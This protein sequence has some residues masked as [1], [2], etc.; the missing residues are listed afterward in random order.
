MR[1]GDAISTRGAGQALRSRVAGVTLRSLNPGFTR[2]ALVALGALWP[3]R[4]G[5]SGLALDALR[6]LWASLA[7]VPLRTLRAD[8]SLYA[9]RTLLAGIPFGT[10]R[11]DVSGIA[12]VALD[13][14]CHVGGRG[15]VLVRDGDGRTVRGLR[16]RSR[17][18]E[19]IFAVEVSVLG[20]GQKRRARRIGI[21][22]CRVRQLGSGV[23]RIRS[24]GRDLGRVLVGVDGIHEQREPVLVLIAAYDH[25][26]HAYREHTGRDVGVVPARDH[27]LRLHNSLGL[28]HGGRIVD[29]ERPGRRVDGIERLR[30]A[31]PGHLVLP[32]EVDCRAGQ[33]GRSAALP[34]GKRDPAPSGV[35]G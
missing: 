28:L 25:G 1:A 6:S 19:P 8:L 15:A 24:I 10:L 21:A 27:D 12:F 11:P 22:S 2:V 35:G 26:L 34:H 3:R 20:S 5:G 32:H 7:R 17:G 23:R 14:L 33:V 4:A 9:L 18:R 30:P 31:L 13:A 16:D 29:L